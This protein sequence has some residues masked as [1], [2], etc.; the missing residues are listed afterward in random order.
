MKKRILGVALALTFV[1]LCFAGLTFSASASTGGYLTTADMNDPSG[2]GMTIDDSGTNPVVTAV[3]D[4]NGWFVV[5]NAKWSTPD[6][7]WNL[8][9][10]FT[11]QTGVKDEGLD[12]TIRTSTNPDFC[13]RFHLF[14]ED[15]TAGG[16]GF[17]LDT[18]VMAEDQLTAANSGTVVADNWLPDNVGQ[19]VHIAV[20][21]V[22]G[23]DTLTYTI[24][25]SDGTLIKS[26]TVDGDMLASGNFF[27][28]AGGFEMMGLDARNVTTGVT[29]GTF[30]NIWLADEANPDAAPSTSDT[31]S[32]G[33]TA[34]PAATLQPTAAADWYSTWGPA[35]AVDPNV[36]IS[37]G[38]NGAG[39]VFGQANADK[40]IE[41][42]PKL[43]G[44][45]TVTGTY[46]FG[47][48]GAMGIT[49]RNDAAKLIVFVQA[50]SESPTGYFYAVRIENFNNNIAFG[51]SDERTAYNLKPDPAADGGWLKADS[52]TTTFNW[53]I[54]HE[55]GTSTVVVKLT[56]AS[57]AVLTTNTID[58]NQASFDFNSLFG[59]DLIWGVQANDGQHGDFGTVSNLQIA[60]AFLLGSNP[61]VTGQTLPIAI[62]A[63]CALSASVIGVVALRSRKQRDAE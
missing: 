7:D 55:D 23:E 44:S 10:D 32:T 12:F 13:L 30:G 26:Y 14:Y 18:K 4:S 5:P 43:S 20:S 60:N 49:F 17:C 54:A 8:E 58:L 1:V 33:T 56:T 63:L 25:K 29:F 19:T 3:G 53:T 36:T 57:G 52:A 42:T 48:A 9:F 28:A 61:S 6:G 34:A 39:A 40:G 51:G 15:N 37:D 11:M 21:H 50:N 47:T 22:D 38:T 27:G 62:V 16:R 35:D 45:W 24:S 59:S 2:T 41:Y 46:T 31:D